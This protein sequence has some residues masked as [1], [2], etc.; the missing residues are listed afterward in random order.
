MFQLSIYLKF[1]TTRCI[2]LL[3]EKAVCDN[4]CAW[5]VYRLTF[6]NVVNIEHK[7]LADNVPKSLAPKIDTQKFTGCRRL[8]VTTVLIENNTEMY[9]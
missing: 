6:L 9:M 1:T 5:K 3:Y 7:V 4:V 2:N 8:L